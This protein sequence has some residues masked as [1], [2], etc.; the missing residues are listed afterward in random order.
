MDTFRLLEA[1]RSINQLFGKLAL[2][3]EKDQLN[4]EIVSL[5]E[6][7][8][9]SRKA[10]ILKLDP[11]RKTLHLEYAPSLP[12]FYNQAIEG[13]E[14]GERV[15]S[16]GAA[17]Y[18]GKSVVVSNI[19]THP[20]WQPYRA[21]AQQANLSACWSVPV[22]SREQQVLGTFAIYS[23][24]PSTPDKEELEIL[25]LLAAL[26]SVAL[27]KYHL[28]DQ[29]HYHFN[30]DP[31]TQCYNRRILY[32]ESESLLAAARQSADGIGC[33][34]VDVDEF[35]Y[36]NDHFGHDVGDTVLVTLAQWLMHHFPKHAVIGRYGG[37]E[38]VAV[39]QLKGRTDFEDFYRQLQSEIKTFF[40]IEDYSVSVSIGAEYA[41]KERL[42]TL[43]A[44]IRS[45]DRRMYQVKRS[46]Q[47]SC[48]R[49]TE[50]IVAENKSIEK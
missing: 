3:L 21:L 25:N 20:N 50:A 32:L 38:F 34:F 47:T 27:E 1:H 14:I 12:G 11:Q 2:G 40:Q 15:G 39:C 8:F 36:I 13:V 18:S 31:L 37:D 10:S 28:E 43:E 26:Y 23:E 24:A 6:R 22:L 5:S 48:V 35:K 46:N 30:R 4:R 33:F 16:C 42:I 41:E 19:N 49:L 17:A 7:L 9:G 45:A 29:L 44:L